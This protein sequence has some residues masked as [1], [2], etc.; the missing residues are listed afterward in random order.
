VTPGTVCKWRGRF[1]VDRLDGLYDE[2]RPGAKR[3]RLRV[4]RCEYR[5]LSGDEQV[6]A[7][8]SA[9]KFGVLRKY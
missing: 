3:S 2:P 5:Q 8:R 6:G 4:W 7:Y 9:L 1:I